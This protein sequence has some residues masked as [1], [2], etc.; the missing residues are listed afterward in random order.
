MLKYITGMIEQTAYCRYFNYW[1]GD[2]LA[3]HLA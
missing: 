3:F 1:S 2:I